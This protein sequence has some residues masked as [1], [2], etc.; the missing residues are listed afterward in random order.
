MLNRF[1]IFLLFSLLASCA[2]TPEFDT[3]QV[4]QSLTPRGVVAEP[5]ES[6]GKTAL[7]GGTILETRNLRDSTEI[8]VLAYPL[9]T[10]HR[11]L[12][13]SEPLGRFIIHR[14]GYL[15]P[16]NYAQGRSITV[17]GKISGSESG[18][19]GESTYTYAVINSEQLYLWS[20]NSERTRTSLHFG[21][22]IGL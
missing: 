4:D 17:L 2:T 10:F 19:V 21:V 3:T 12:L 20:Q 13:D 1:L 8:E 22:G 16:T 11:P 9:N 15:E 14:T 7:W 18:K 6:I 5:D